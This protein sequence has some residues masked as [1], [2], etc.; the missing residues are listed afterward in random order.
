MFGDEQQG[1]TETR[2]KI[3]TTIII[4]NMRAKVFE[5]PI[6]NVNIS[7]ALELYSTFIPEQAIF[8]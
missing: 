8:V 5:N 1:D 3:K 7:V 2:G 6:K 4:R